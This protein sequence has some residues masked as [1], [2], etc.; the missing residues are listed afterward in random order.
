V[1]VIGVKTVAGLTQVKEPSRRICDL[2]MHRPNRAADKRSK[3][4]RNRG[5]GGAPLKQHR[6]MIE[7]DEDLCDGCGICLPNCHEGALKIVDGKVRLV[8]EALCDGLG[9]CLQHCPRGAL[10]IVQREAAP[11]DMAQAGASSPAVATA[12]PPPPPPHAGGGCPGS[13]VRMLGAPASHASSGGPGRPAGATLRATP[14]G[15]A[16]PV[17]ESQLSH[18]PVQIRLVPPSAPF[19]QGASLLVAADCVPVAMAGFHSAL[20]AG[21]AVMIGCPKF[22]D[23][24]DATQRFARIFSQS[25]VR[26]V[27]VAVMEVPCCMSQPTAVLRGLLAS[28]RQLDVE[29]VVIGVDG[30]IKERRAL[31]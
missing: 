8:S 30:T 17:E 20:L 12:A 19:L 4:T 14:G 24:E 1:E 6:A 21:R 26:S 22:D 2:Q 27:V 28:G 16:G 13:R 9:A 18:W 15:G 3:Q 11:F 5:E 25:D 10:R 23:L 29:L 7:I 31:S